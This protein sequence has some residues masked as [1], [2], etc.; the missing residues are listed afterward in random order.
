MKKIRLVWQLSS[1]III[2]ILAGCLP[3]GT[4]PDNQSALETIVATTLTAIAGEAPAAVETSTP[5]ATATPDVPA[6]IPPRA[7]QVAYVKDGNVYIW[8]EGESSV[9][10]TSTQ[11]AIRVSI[12]DDGQFIAYERGDPNNFITTSEL[13]V[14]NTSGVTNAQ[15]LVSQAE[16][17][18][19][20][21][22]SPF[23]NASGMGIDV[24]DWKPKT[25]QIFYSTVP[26]FEGPGYAPSEDMRMINVDTMEKKTIFDYGQGGIFYF[27]PDGTQVALS[28]SDHISLANADG[29]NLRPNVLTFPLVG[30]YSE[31][32][33]R[34]RPHWATDSGSLRVAIPPEDTLATPIPP[35]ELWTIP[36]DGSPA[37]R[38]G[39]IFAIPFAWPD[40]AFSPTLER[41]GYAQSY[42][43]PTENLREIH[44]ASSDGAENMI[45]AAGTSAEFL[46]WTPDG[47]RF[48]YLL[49][50]GTD[51]GMYLGSISGDA[52]TI[53]T[54]PNTIQQ[55]RWVD[56]SRFLFLYQTGNVQE[57][58][59]S[60]V[61]GTNHAFIDS[62]PADTYTTYDFTQ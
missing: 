42:G 35:T 40:N 50:N 4:P 24:L 60:H 29:S 45:Y 18:A 2:F 27:S 62:M 47:T 28:S 8:T 52:S 59:I 1:L 9:G 13:W 33:Y 30:T 34:P 61:G 21:I 56:N 53:T 14:V 5:V 55:M 23:P 17:D 49:D 48:V 15:L 58:R 11:D 44:I 19:L 25:H 51:Y 54:A 32:Q 39:T 36:V 16:M 22:A 7:L 3:T 31:Y 38:I 43:E 46:H 10:L 37:T 57:L 26:R 6:F 20:K 41:V 12:S